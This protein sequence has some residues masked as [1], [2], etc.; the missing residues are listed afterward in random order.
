MFVKNLHYMLAM[1]CVVAQQS[2]LAVSTYYIAL[3]G[4][5]LTGMQ[6]IAQIINNVTL[7]FL[8]A[9]SA[10]LVSSV[11]V[12]LSVK[13]ANQLWLSYCSR[14]LNGVTK[15]PALCSEPNKNKVVQWLSGEASATVP[16]AVQFYLDLVSLVLGIIFTLFVFYLSVG[17]M[18]AL[19]VFMVLMI[20]TALVMVMRKNIN[21]LAGSMQQRKLSA[22]IYV[23]P[24]FN[25]AAYGS[26]AMKSEGFEVFGKRANDYFTVVNRYT[27]LEQIVACLPVVLAVFAFVIVLSTPGALP[28]AAIGTL[29]A[30]LPRSLQLFGSIHSLSMSLSQYFLIRSKID[31]LNGFVEGLD[32]QDLSVNSDDVVVVDCATGLSLSSEVFF[33]RITHSAIRAGRFCVTGKNGSGKTTLLKRLKFSVPDS[34]LL[35]PDSY[36]LEKSKDRSTG[37]AKLDELHAVLQ[38]N[39]RLLLLDEWDANLDCENTRTIDSILEEYAQVKLIVEVRHKSANTP[40][41]AAQASH[42]PMAM[43]TMPGLPSTS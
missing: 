3:A 42:T 29:V 7:F 40:P 21:A 22:L 35:L 8:F 15:D 18:F 12:L 6:H 20:S 2:L 10:Y 9:L 25:R 17:L 31:N 5:G 11:S 28:L 39:S 26:A 32:R 13:A 43:P 4:A 37:Q 41:S 14:V 33:Q 23:E 19:A 30:L 27:S 34:L 36:F 16:Q 38:E 24:V 1:V